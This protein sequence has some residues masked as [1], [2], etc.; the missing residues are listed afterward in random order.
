MEH[1]RIKLQTGEHVLVQDVEHA[2]GGFA[3][4]PN[5]LG[6][7][8]A[9][10][11]VCVCVCVCVCMRARVC[12]CVCV[13]VCVRVLCVRTRVCACTCVTVASASYA[14]IAP[15]HVTNPSLE[16]ANIDPC[17]TERTWR[18][19]LAVQM[20]TTPS[21]SFLD[22]CLH[23]PCLGV[24]AIFMN[25]WQPGALHRSLSRKRP[26]LPSTLRTLAGHGGRCA[27]RVPSCVPQ[28]WSYQGGG[29]T[30]GW[31]AEGNRTQSYAAW[32]QRDQYGPP[33]SERSTMGSPR[34]PPSRVSPSGVQQWPS[35]GHGP[36][37]SSRPTGRTYLRV[38]SRGWN[39][40][41]QLRRART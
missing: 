40:G 3:V 1:Y 35:R 27:P 31:A 25:M 37:H 22:D 28:A 21:M 16:F 32:R 14:A 30:S 26:A 12:V 11:C 8:G 5:E 39:D 18:Q 23:Q 20:K 9:R 4:D 17:R 33:F 29:R 19:R 6:S 15:I 24:R 34:Q 13:R 7:L 41:L 10:E 36:S 38:R 2:G